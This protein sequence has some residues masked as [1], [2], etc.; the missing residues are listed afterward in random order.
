MLEAA[1][2]AQLLAAEVVPVPVPVSAVPL[3]VSAFSAA[4]VVVVVAEVLI[5]AGLVAGQGVGYYE[6]CQV[7]YLLVVQLPGQTASFVVSAR[8]ESVASLGWLEPAQLWAFGEE[9][10]RSQ[11]EELGL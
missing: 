8:A 6:Q 3:P 5:V 4:T 2:A 9:L 10:L 1:S 7:Q 11:W